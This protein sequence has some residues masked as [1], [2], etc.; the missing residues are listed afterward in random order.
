MKTGAQLLAEVKEV[1]INSL[2]VVFDR[3]FIGECVAPNRI[4]EI[5]VDG[6]LIIVVRMCLIEL[7]G[8]GREIDVGVL[9]KPFGHRT[10]NR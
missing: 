6:Q 10:R 2:N 4:G 7:L 9:S 8:Q 5:G 1:L 3:H